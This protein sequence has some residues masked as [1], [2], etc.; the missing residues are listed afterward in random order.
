MTSPDQALAAGLGHHRAGRLR[1]AIAI[2]REVLGAVPRHAE[3][4]H[5]LGVALLQAGQTGDALRHLQT[6]VLLDGGNPAHQANLAEGLR[7]AGRLDEAAAAAR[8]ALSLDPGNAT[9]LNTLGAIRQA[10][11][12]LE[13]AAAHYRKALRLN[14]ESVEIL[15][16]LGGA[17]RQSGR[18]GEAEKILSKALRLAPGIPEIRFNLGLALLGLGR[19]PEAEDHLRAVVAARPNHAEAWNG[20][21]LA[22]RRRA[23]WAE[24]IPALARA[25][26]LAPENADFQFALGAALQEAGKAD[27]ATAAYGKAVDLKGGPAAFPEAAIP[28]GR[29]AK[30]NGDVAGAR[31]VFAALRGTGKDAAARLHQVTSLPAILESE[32][33]VEATRAE[34]DRALDELL[35][36][37]LRIEDPLGAALGPLFYLAYH[38]RDD[39]PFQEKMARLY[40]QACPTLT[41]EA[42]KMGGGKGRMKVGFVSSHFHGHTIGKLMRGFVAELNRERFETVAFLLPRPDD[43]V[44]AFIREKAGKA[45]DL[46]GDLAGARKAIE[47][48][49]P[50]VLIYTDIGMDAFTYFLAFS[51]LAPVQV[52]AWG[53]PVTTGLETVDFFLSSPDL[54]PPGNEAH[55]TEKLARLRDVTTYYYRP[56]PE[57]LPD[58]AALGLPEDRRL[59]ACLQTLFKL[60]PSFDASLAHILRGDP[61][62]QLLLI[63]GTPAWRATL[64]ARFAKA[65]P[66]VADRIRFLGRM[67]IRDFM[68]VVK[69]ADVVLDTPH[70]SGGNTTLETLAV[71]APTVTLPGAFMRGRVSAAMLRQ[72]GIEDEIA[73]GP[74]DYVAKALALAGDRDRRE[75]VRRRIAEGRDALFEN[76]RVIA[77][78]E[79]FLSGS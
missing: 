10:E 17:L 44:R 26:E 9:A 42:R 53:H 15:N 34:L 36:S 37:D 24:A 29:I 39:R 58:R 23:A 70:F 47:A 5:L 43:P 56:E 41:H 51:R 55:Y 72:A 20:L 7:R 59:Y 28:L 22:L 52:A 3:A 6:A 19:G 65:I 31:R 75:A 13:D 78:L 16:N 71:G 18:P 67:P 11:G 38:G 27:E 49:R 62:G 77:D 50:G 35:D 57:R 68:G 64:E 25:A 4:Q 40:R 74:E 66:D 8:R 2:Y 48:E 30:Q 33:H 61:E 21:G 32:N 54:D 76:R 14:P 45:V 60:H 63:E 73:T 12:R 69:A 46:P 79:A 1:E